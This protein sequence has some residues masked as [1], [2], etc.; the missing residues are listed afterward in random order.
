VPVTPDRLAYVIFTS[1][2]TGAPKGVEL[3]HAAAANTVADIGER[4][5]LGPADR[6]L[7]VS[8]LGFDLSVFDVFGP[9]GAGGALVL[10]GE[11]DRREARR[12]RALLR[13]HGVTVWNSVPA[14]LEM[15]LAAG[16]G[17]LPECLRLALVSGDW[18]ALDLP[19][20]LAQQAPG[21]RL[22]ALGGATE[23]AIWSNAYSGPVAGTGWRSMPYGYPLRN[24]RFRV[25]DGWGRDCPDWVPGELW[26]GGAGV[27]RG[28]RGDPVRTAE[29]FVCHDGERWYRTG[30]R[31]RYRPDGTL[32]FLGRT[33]HQV[34]LRGH[35][36]ELGE[37]EAAL[38]AHP[39]VRAAV[40]AVV[41]NRLAAAVTGEADPAALRAFTAARLPAHM[42][43]EAVVR[44]AALPVS[45]TGKVDRA[46]VAVLLAGADPAPG[47]APPDGAL[48]R[49][50]AGL[51]SDVLGVGVDDRAAGFFA[52]G[53]DSLLAT[54]LLD[55]LRRALGVELPLRRVL[56]D[57]TVAGMAAAVAEL[58][59]D[60]E[61]GAL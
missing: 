28:Y 59:A 9:L 8:E 2:S 24:Q 3:T 44:L 27:A 50:V 11:D 36:I 40:V 13:W 58:T 26:I 56:A 60:T 35:R 25:V 5:G 48:E 19:D 10:L 45:R 38:G 7:G 42:V 34:K 41:G 57:P 46:A 17:P 4:Y 61:E 6:V 37:V 47:G 18:V 32:E 33:D 15:L 21:C 43:P 12:W 54:T 1:G 53:G 49:T 16:D 39:G 51:W 29:R 31:G 55:R 14:L 30:D 22:V 20:R 23:A 52:L